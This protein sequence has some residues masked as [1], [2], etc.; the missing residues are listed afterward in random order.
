ML[1]N[2][3]WTLTLTLSFGIINAQDEWTLEQCI[4]RALDQ[5]LTIRDAELSI[6]NA[7]INQK[8]SRQA[9]YPSLN[10][11]TN[12]F[13]NFGRTIDPTS[14]E[15][16][17]TTFFSNGL[18][19]NSGVTLYS[20]GRIKNTIKQSDL[21]YQA[22]QK[23]YDQSLN[24]ISL[25]V[26]SAFLNVLFAREN[27]EN[28]NKQ[29]EITQEQLRQIELLIESGS[30]PENERLDIEAQ[31]AT[32]EQAVVNNQNTLDIAML[33][34]K[35]LLRFS[36]DYNMALA[37]PPSVDIFTDPNLIS[38]KEIYES[39]LKTQK[40]IEASELRVQ[41]SEIGIKI[42]KSSLYPTLTFGGSLQTNYSNQGRRIVGFE[43]FR[44]TQDVFI[45]NTRVTIGQDVDV[46]IVEK[47]PYLD[48]VD[49]N[50]SYGFGFN[51]N[52][53]IYNNYQNKASVERAKI[54]AIR[55]QNTLE[56]VKDNLKN[57]VQQALAD[58]RAAKK[59]LEAAEKNQVAQQAAYDNAIKRYELGAINTFD[60]TTIQNQ[61]EQAEI[62]L[63][64]SRYDYLFRTKVLDFYL[65][66]PITLK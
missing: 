10:G 33:G 34:L 66:R 4:E 35:Q 6:D 31:I 65:G 15:F 28:A 56:I 24:D 13:W 20:G 52:I 39:S 3:L 8:T 2:L 43:T 5:D 61:L 53:P 58:A 41:S 26:A 49:E 25:Q 11:G 23:D 12:A 29:L 37:A 46:P 62:N 17:T 55:A 51:M 48:Q 44:Q 16:I 18:S 9:R 63:I 27:L 50:L 59:S 36:P 14:N 40:S 30:R 60:L 47:N 38:F 32:R 22:A 45:D 42:A 7:T 54:G 64:I 19:L 21:D 57:T 1:R